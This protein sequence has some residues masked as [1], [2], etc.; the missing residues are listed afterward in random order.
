MWKVIQKFSPSAENL[1]YCDLKG[2]GVSVKIEY[3]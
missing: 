2:K 1:N 3:K